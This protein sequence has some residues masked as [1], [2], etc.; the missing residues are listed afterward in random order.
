MATAA[1]KSRGT[2]IQVDTTGTGT[3]ASIPE[4]KDIVFPTPTSD[5]IDVTNQDSPSNSKE[6][7]PGDIDPQEVTFSCNYL[8]NNTRHMALI[9]DQVSGV[10]RPYRVK[11]VGDVLAPTF[12]AYVRT[13]A[14]RGPVSGVYEMDVTLRVSGAVTEDTTP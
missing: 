2:Q 9:T 10:V 7:V 4:A 6:F 1:L 3:W 13:V 14:R 5:E 8:W 12:N 11:L